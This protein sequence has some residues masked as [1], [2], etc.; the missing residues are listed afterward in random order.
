[1]PVYIRVR[2]YVK[3]LNLDIVE[4][5]EAAGID[6]TEFSE[7]MD[8]VRPIFAEDI[9]AICLALDVSANVFLA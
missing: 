6:V 9:R 3:N 4:V 2:N 7:M 1:M 5:A 8:G